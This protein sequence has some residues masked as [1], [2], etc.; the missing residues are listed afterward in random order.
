MVLALAPV[1]ARRARHASYLYDGFRAV[2]FLPSILRQRELQALLLAALPIRSVVFAGCG[3]GDEMSSLLATALRNVQDIVAIDIADVSHDVFE[4][5]DR[6]AK[7]ISFFDCDLLDLEDVRGSGSFDLVQAGFVFHDLTE[8]EKD[9]GFGVAARVLKSGGYFLVSDFFPGDLTPEDLYGAFIDEA[10]VEA[11]AG[12]MPSAA[13]DEFLGDGETPGLLRTITRA[14][15]GERDF[16][17]RPDAAADRARRHGLRLIQTRVN[18]I[19]E[20][21]RVLLFQKVTI[22]RRDVLF[23]I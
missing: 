10:E 4:A 6:L 17:D 13:R 21:M 3:F 19:N 16:F 18:D 20:T 7:P 8:A 9:E 14:A 23:S 22:G 2:V 15:A 1:T 11:R 5:A 12:R